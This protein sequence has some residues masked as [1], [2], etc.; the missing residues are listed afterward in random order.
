MI[1]IDPSILDLRWE[2]TK[3]GIMEIQDL[4]KVGVETLDLKSQI[5]P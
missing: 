1:T 2:R 3:T 4:E 5:E